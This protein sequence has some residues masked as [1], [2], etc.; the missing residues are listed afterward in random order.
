MES[1]DEVQDGDTLA[2]LD[3]RENEINRAAVTVER[4][5]ARKTRDHHLAFGNTAGAQIAGLEEQRLEE[6]LSILQEKRNI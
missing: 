4:N 1:G 6:Q 3:G 5:K 2:I